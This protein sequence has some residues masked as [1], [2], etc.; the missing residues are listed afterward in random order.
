MLLHRIVRC[1]ALLAA[2]SLL[3]CVPRGHR[4]NP[5]AALIPDEPVATDPL[6]VDPAVRTGTLPNGLTW[7]T[8][9]NTAPPD[10]AILRLVVRAGSVLEDDDQLGVAHYVEHM[11]FNGTEHFPGNELVSYLESIGS[12]FG[13]HINAHTSWDET[14]YKL[15][16]PT[17]DPDVL[18]RGLLVLADFARGIAFDPEEFEAERGVV[19]EEWRLDQGLAD[20]MQDAVF[21]ALWHG[22][23][24][25]ERRPIGTEQS[26]RTLTVEAARRFYDDWYRPDLM[27][28]IAVGEFDG[29]AM[30]KMIADHFGGMQGPDEPRERLWPE[31]PEHEEPILTIFADPELPVTAVEVADKFDQVEQSTWAG[32]R[33]TL[34]DWLVLSMVVERMQQRA[35]SGDAPWLEAW[36]DEERLTPSRGVR[37]LM[38]V[39]SEGRAVEAV[40]GLLEELERVQRYGFTEAELGRARASVMSQMQEYYD[41]R[42]TTD[43]VQH[44]QE[45]IRVFTTGEGMPGEEVE[46]LLATRWLPQILLDEI[47]EAGRAWMDG[48][49]RLISVYQPAKEGLAV[50]EAAALQ[51]V[52]DAVAAREIAPPAAEEADAPLMAELP[53]PGEIVD[54]GYR[55]DL[56]L[57]TWTLANG[58][59]VVVKP[60]RF[61]AEDVR[62]EA[63]SPGGTSTIDDE[64]FVP[65]MTATAIA[66]WSGTGDLDLPALLRSMSGKRVG[67]NYWLEREYDKLQGASSVEDL[68]LL[69]QRL[70][71]VF[72]GPRF[73]PGAL[74]RERDLRRASIENR[75]ADPEAAFFDEVDDRWW[76]ANPRYQT[77]T[78][79][80]LERMDLAASEVVYRQRFGDVGD[81]TF[82]FVGN[83]RPDE[84]RPLVERYIASLPTAGTS[85]QWVDRGAERLPGVHKETI[86]LGTANRATVVLRFHGPFEA[87]WMSRNRLISMVDILDVRLREVLREELGGTYGADASA[88]SDDAGGAYEVEVRFRCDPERVEELLAATWEVIEELRTT[89]VA[90]R[91]VADLQAKDLR[92]REEANYDNEWWAGA[93]TGAIERGE[94]M[95]ELLTFEERTMSLTAEEVRATAERL[96]SPEQYLEMVLLPAVVEEDVGA[97]PAAVPER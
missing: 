33:R 23:R 42:E 31:L 53:E 41:E 61:K 37:S 4:V 73:S 20:R 84:L 18:D 21:P 97:T 60:T 47:N 50:P 67:L 29:V 17:T 26:L 49:G 90:E 70:H 82:V 7:Y 24:Y 30:Q 14:V 43:S 51:A 85:E 55:E 65:G 88:G 68:E 93:L 62:F 1:V 3:A 8:Q 94:E 32:Y 16:V 34:V 9:R 45:I 71:L 69:M 25:L 19:L 58:A 11:A 54:E 91:Y 13:A 66:G 48:T 22:S 86:R 28:V 79:E 44:A 5:Y 77:W 52:V 36:P 96:L 39:A 75:G 38:A 74:E 10:R 89:P 81:F 27:A 72:A 2:L 56:N 59:T 12:G 35:L 80:H 46:Y 40:D 63:T 64:V 76:Q 15:E 95:G 87:T 57:T 78:T 92:Q 83:L 6:P